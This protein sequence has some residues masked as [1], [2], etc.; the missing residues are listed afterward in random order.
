MIELRVSI[1][2]VLSLKAKKHWPQGHYIVSRS[3]EI[4]DFLVDGVL[5]GTSTLS[6]IP[7]DV[8]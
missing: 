4:A 6:R 7:C 2:H 8:I 1:S 5:S 3:L